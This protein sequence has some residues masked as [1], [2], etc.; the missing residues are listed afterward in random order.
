MKNVVTAMLCAAACASAAHADIVYTLPPQP[1]SI[2]VA[3]LDEQ[4][5]SAPIDLDNDGVPEFILRAGF[6]LWMELTIEPARPGAFLGTHLNTQDL[7]RLP[8]G[9]AVGPAEA[10]TWNGSLLFYNSGFVT[11]PFGEWEPNQSPAFF[12]VRFDIGGQAHLGWARAQ[13]T[14]TILNTVT[15]SVLDYAYESVPGA[16]IL[17][18]AIPAPGAGIV[19]PLLALAGARRRRP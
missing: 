19:L 6:P 8:A 4:I 1:I 7:P 9:A 16:P 2:T 15:I 10:Y 12:G 14:E 17:T 13:V 18:G 5:Y 3:Q 11:G